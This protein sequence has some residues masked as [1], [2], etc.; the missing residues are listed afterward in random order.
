MTGQKNLR[1]GEAGRNAQCLRDV[2]ED[3]REEII[4]IP[5]VSAS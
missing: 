3:K 4:Y 5:R 1:G 2:K